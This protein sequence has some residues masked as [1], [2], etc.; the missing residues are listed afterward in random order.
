VYVPPHNLIGYTF[1]VI[2]LYVSVLNIMKTYFVGIKLG[3]GGLVRA[4]GGVV[5]ECLKDA[6]I[7]ALR[8]QM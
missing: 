2:I 6:P 1:H 7:L 8:N 3:T 4:S 5:S